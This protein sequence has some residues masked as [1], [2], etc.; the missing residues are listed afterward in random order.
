M[1]GFDCD[2]DALRIVPD[3]QSLTGTGRENPGPEEHKDK[4]KFVAG[5]KIPQRQRQNFKQIKNEAGL[6]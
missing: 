2:S 4:E 1:P 3:T 5:R 6:R